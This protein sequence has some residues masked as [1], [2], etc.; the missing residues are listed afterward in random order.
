MLIVPIFAALRFSD[1]KKKIN[2]SL[3][4]NLQL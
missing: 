2:K 1:K 4:S 3:S